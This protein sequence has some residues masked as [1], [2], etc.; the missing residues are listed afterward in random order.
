[1]PRQVKSDPR[2]ARE[3]RDRALARGELRGPTQERVPSPSPVSFAQKA[4]D[5]ATRAM[6]DAFLEKRGMS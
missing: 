5:P 2:L 4:E 3:R 6:I 1:M